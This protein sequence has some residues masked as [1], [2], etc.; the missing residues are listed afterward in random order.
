M[1]SISFTNQEL[2]LVEGKL[3]RLKH[4]LLQLASRLLCGAVRGQ[5]GVVLAERI[6]ARA[7]APNILK[8]DA[9]AG[10]SSFYIAGVGGGRV[11][12]IAPS[13]PTAPKD[14]TY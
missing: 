1:I 2:R 8:H 10:S 4:G 13:V 11:L 14:D 7:Q 5:L 6:S 3:V 12:L 9:Q